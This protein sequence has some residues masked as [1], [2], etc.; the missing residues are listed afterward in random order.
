MA[1]GGD[2][3]GFDDPALDDRLDHDDDD[4]DDSDE[5]QEQNRTQS[6]QLGAASTPY[7]GGGEIE[8]QTRQHEKTGL[9]DT[10]YDKE[11]PL[12]RRAGSITDLQRRKRFETK[13]QKG[14]KLYKGRFPRAN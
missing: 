14:C 8:M 7:Q 1:T 12:L 4:D 11:T 9:P 6:F 3:F 5:E 2:A 10:S 13:T